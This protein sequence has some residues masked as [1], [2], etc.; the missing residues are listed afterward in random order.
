MPDAMPPDK[1]NR[2]LRSWSEEL[3]SA[4]DRVDY[5]IGNKHQPTKGSYRE[6]LLRRLISRVL[7]KRFRVSTGFV[8]R[9]YDDPSR[10]IDILIWDAQSHSALLEEGEL[11]ILTADAV[12]AMIEVKSILDPEEL[13]KSLELLNPKWLTYWR[14]TTASSTHGLTQQVPNV[15]Y[16]AVFAYDASQSTADGVAVAVFKELSDFYRARF[17]NDAERAMSQTGWRFLNW[18]NLVDSIC[19]ARGPLFEQVRAFVSAAGSESQQPAYV[20][21]AT[22]ELSVG[23][24]CMH[25]LAHLTEFEAGEAARVT[26]RSPT[27]TTTPGLCCF[28]HP[29]QNATGVRAWS[30]NV[31][32]DSLWIADP[33]LWE[34]A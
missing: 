5:L 20:S 25:L 7:P 28:G 30:D 24:F 18:T 23:R 34:I 14:H 21:L 33:P 15:P 29:P 9:W 17:G 3:L 22:G 13:R 31:P 12:A 8:Y 1:W 10:Q 16:R 26:L 27:T 4:I 32:L 2:L 6:T 11:V 19:V